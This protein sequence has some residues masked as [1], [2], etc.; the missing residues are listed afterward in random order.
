MRNLL[1]YQ[2][3]RIIFIFRIIF[4]FFSDHL[5]R[6]KISKARRATKDN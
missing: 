5:I 1:Y 3:A 4:T 6:H 2:N